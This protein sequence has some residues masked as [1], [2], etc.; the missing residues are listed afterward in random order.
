MSIVILICAV[1]LVGGARPS[2][3]GARPRTGVKGASQ[4]EWKVLKKSSFAD[5]PIRIVNVKGKG[6]EII[7]DEK[8]KGDDADWLRDLTITVENVSGKAITHLNFALFFPPRGN[9]STGEVSYTFDLMFGVSPQSEHYAESRKRRPDRVIKQKEKFDLSLSTEQY[10][11]IRKV[12]NDLGYPP[13]IREVEIWISEVGFD[14]GTYQIGSRIY[15]SRGASKE[16]EMPTN[17]ALDKRAFLVKAG[18]RT[19]ATAPVQSRCGG[20]LS[21]AWLLVCSKPGCKLPE[22]GV[23]YY[24]PFNH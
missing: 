6:K 12:L 22:D 3:G 9:G 21:R 7:M 5:E 18:F 17:E 16:I 4:N 13:D 14:D 23:D 1:V 24:H 20:A 8:F 19:G 2:E 15:A 11:H 10:E